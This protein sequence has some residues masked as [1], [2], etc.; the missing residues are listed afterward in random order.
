MAGQSER[1]GGG[2][3]RLEQLRLDALLTPEELATRID[4]RVSAR[5][6]RR[7]E[8]SGH[9]ARVSTLGPLAEFFEV[10][11]SDLVRDALPVGHSTASASP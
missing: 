4:G 10:P 3:T 1:Q 6:I 2:V 11:A 7:I 8:T 9:T 5:T